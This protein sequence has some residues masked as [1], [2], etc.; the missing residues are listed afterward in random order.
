M[1][2]FFY[3]DG[4]PDH[5]LKYYSVMISYS[6]AFQ[7]LN[8]DYLVAVQTAPNNSWTNP[9]ERLM[10]ILL[11]LGL[12]SVSTSQSMT[13]NDIEAALKSCNSMADIRKEAVSNTL[14]KSAV[15]DSLAPVI[16]LIENRFQ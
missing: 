2:F 9:C 15:A 7:W 3:H 8:L 14:L 13:S 1:M 16:S 11:N 6:C 5:R 10:S 4:G 12:Q